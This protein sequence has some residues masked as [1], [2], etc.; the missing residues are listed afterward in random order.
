MSTT[1]YVFFDGCTFFVGSLEY[2]QT[3][4]T[5]IFFKSSDYN[6]CCEVADQQNEL[7]QGRERG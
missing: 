3:A 5:E 1:H 4:D 7:A 6:K 2:D